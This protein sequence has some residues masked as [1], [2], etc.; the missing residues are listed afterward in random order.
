MKAKPRGKQVIPKKQKAVVV[1]QRAPTVDLIKNLRVPKMDTLPSCRRV[2]RNILR[3]V[4]RDEIPSKKGW[5]MA[6]IVKE[7]TAI[8]KD[9]TIEQEAALMRAAFRKAVD[10]GAIPRGAI[11]AAIF[12]GTPLKGDYLPADGDE[13]PHPFDTH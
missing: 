12:D 1:A 2:L 7:I 9:I 13:S 4:A 6:S 8:T 5:H 3:M 11:P 10:S